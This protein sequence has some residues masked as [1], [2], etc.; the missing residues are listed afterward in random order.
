MTIEQSEA[1][2]LGLVISRSYDAV[3]RDGPAVFVAHSRAIDLGA[4][5]I[6]AW[7]GADQAPEQIATGIEVVTGQVW[8]RGGWAI[9]DQ[10]GLGPLAVD[11]DC[12]PEEIGRLANQAEVRAAS[13]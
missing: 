5:L 9:V 3:P 2:A 8:R 11:E 12:P 13:A 4:A 7:I 6:G 1:E 10:V